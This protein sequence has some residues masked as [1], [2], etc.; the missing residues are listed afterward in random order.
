MAAPPH[1]N[2]PTVRGTSSWFQRGQKYQQTPSSI[3]SLGASDDTSNQRTCLTTNLAN[4]PSNHCLLSQWVGKIPTAPRTAL[5]S[6]EIQKTS[7]VGLIVEVV[8]GSWRKIRRVG[9]N[10][11]KQA[12]P[13][14][15]QE[16]DHIVVSF[17]RWGAMRRACARGINRRHIQ[18]FTRSTVIFKPARGVRHARGA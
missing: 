10:N 11:A 8:Y 17:G 5:D 14:Q 15:A 4:A 1:S 6:M 18:S 3:V 16:C 2:R 12:A 9:V 13:M 7:A